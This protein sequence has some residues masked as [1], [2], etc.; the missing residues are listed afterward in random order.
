MVLIFTL[1]L[2]VDV[3]DVNCMT[4]NILY[5]CSQF[6]YGNYSILNSFLQGATNEA[7]SR[8]GLGLAGSTYVSSSGRTTAYKARLCKA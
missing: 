1:T 3:N 8:L 6:A 2:N 5:L 4:D 7:D